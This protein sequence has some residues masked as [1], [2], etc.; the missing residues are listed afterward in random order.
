MRR[1]ELDYMKVRTPDE[2]IGAIRKLKESP[3]LY[4]T[5]VEN[6]LARCPSFPSTR[7]PHAGG[8]SWRGRWPGLLERWPAYPSLIK[9]FYRLAKYAAQ[10][11]LH[12][13]EI[14]KYVKSAI[15]GT[16]PSGAGTPD[17]PPADGDGRSCASTPR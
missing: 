11:T 13:Y 16:G 4:R 10:S 12:K 7:S 14:L 9:R 1:T 2:A 6:G 5:M 17:S 3:E 8:R 15:T